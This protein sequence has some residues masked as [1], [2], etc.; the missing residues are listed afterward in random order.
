[1]LCLCICVCIS[2]FA[3]SGVYITHT[4]TCDHGIHE[5]SRR[6]HKHWAISMRTEHGVWQTH[7]PMLLQLVVH[8]KRL[9]YGAAATVVCVACTVSLCVHTRQ[10]GVQM[11]IHQAVLKHAADERRVKKKSHTHTHRTRVK[12]AISSLFSYSGF[13]SHDY[14]HYLPSRRIFWDRM[15]KNRLPFWSS[16]QEILVAI[17]E[18]YEECVHSCPIGMP[19]NA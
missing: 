11:T 3:F 9:P 10:H 19:R 17:V 8:G 14:Y 2:A 15:K 12:H 1:M 7:M 4:H 5:D 18:A 13:F 6:D 16:I